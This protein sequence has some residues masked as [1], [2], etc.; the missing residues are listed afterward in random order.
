MKTTVFTGIKPRVE[1]ARQRFTQAADSNVV[2]LR[3]PP[4]NGNCCLLAESND[5]GRSQM[6]EPAELYACLYAKEFPAQALLRLRPELH[7]TACVVMDGEPPLQQI[8]S[9]NTKARLLGM[10][11]A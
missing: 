8:C 10:T 6:N 1:V 7:N 3:K 9:L 4:Q 11:T 5:M 2:P